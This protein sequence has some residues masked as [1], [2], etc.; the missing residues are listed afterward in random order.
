MSIQRNP[1]WIEL[2]STSSIFCWLHSPKILLHDHAFIIVGAIGPEYIHTYRSIRLLADRL[3]ESGNIAIRYDPIGMGNSSSTLDDTNLWRKWLASPEAIRKYTEN[4]FNIK[5]F[6]IIAFRS[7]SLLLESYLNTYKDNEIIFWYPYIHGAAFV[8]DMQM[9]DSIPKQT[10][11][12]RS[13]LDGGGYPLT[14]ETQDALLKVKLLKQSFNKYQNVLILENGEIATK[15]PLS[16]RIKSSTPNIKTEFIN[17][18]GSMARQAELSIVPV[19]NIDTICKWVNEIST[20]ERNK[21]III[22]DKNSL[23]HNH[24]TEKTIII[25][26]ERS[27][28]GVLTLPIEDSPKN[29]LLLTNSGS[30]HQVGPNRF[31]VDTARELAKEGIATFR[32]DLSNLG[33]S[34]NI[35][36][37]DSYHPYPKTAS[38]D[39]NSVLEYFEPTMNFQKIIIAGLCSGAHN[40]FQSALNTKST[41]VKGLILINIITFYWKEGQSILTPEGSELEINA[42]EYQNNMLDIKKWFGVLLSPNK[43]W[44][45]TL[46]AIKFSIKKIAAMFYKILSAFGYRKLTLLDADLYAITSRKIKLHFLYSENEPTL[47]ILKSQANIATTE[48]MKN[49]LL[50]IYK[51]ENSDHTFSSRHARNILINTIISSAKKIFIVNQ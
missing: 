27:V 5:H 43:I 42:S 1:I 15:S 50:N 40:S 18:L 34:P 16:N 14:I 24:F 17:G 39:I 44:R 2:D 32:M 49:G 28:F 21:Q 3:S 20:D 47:S 48:L 13:S 45:L 6:T 37:D 7:G 10:E 11:N 29:L 19:N 30:G 9:L 46:F 31:H 22:P 51:I 41:K 35:F 33:D 25:N 38:D 12:N 4:K 26:Y 23:T 8:R 36:I